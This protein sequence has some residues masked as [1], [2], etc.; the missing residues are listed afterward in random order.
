VSEKRFAGEKELES[1]GKTTAV[2]VCDLSDPWEQGIS[3]HE[4]AVDDED[5][6]E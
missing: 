3:G 4:R 2:S 5:Y 6:N 1:L